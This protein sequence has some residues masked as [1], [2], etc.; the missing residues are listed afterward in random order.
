MPHLD[1]VQIDFD[2][3]AGAQ[4]FTFGLA[5]PR[6]HED[7]IVSHF[8]DGVLT[9][10][11]P[12][13]F[14][15]PPGINLWVKG[16][17]NHIK[18]GIQALEGIVET[19]WSPSTFTM[20]WKITRPG[21]PIRFEQGEPICMVVPIPRGL[22]ESLDPMLLPIDANP[23][24][25]LEY[26]EWQASRRQF[27]QDLRSHEPDAVRRGWQREYIKG[28]LPSGAAAPEHQTRLSVKEFRR[29]D[30]PPSG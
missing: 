29:A 7:R 14:R 11:I 25:E 23:D 16:P 21:L 3:Q 2:G 19:D 5:P 18:D 27:N 17:V 1:G 10:T 28:V 8:G 6:R 9:F 24:L 15:T 12:Y 4:V 13:L 22:T 20:N 26:Q 30:A